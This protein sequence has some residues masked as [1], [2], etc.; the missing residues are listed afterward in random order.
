MFLSVFYVISRIVLPYTACGINRTADLYKVQRQ[1]LIAL[2]WT[3]QPM[4]IIKC[5]HKSFSF[6]FV[7]SF[8]LLGGILSR[9]NQTKK[10]IG[11]AFM[12]PIRFNL[13]LQEH[14]NNNNNNHKTF[15][16]C[17]IN[18]AP[19]NKMIVLF[20]LDFEQKLNEILLLPYHLHMYYIGKI[21]KE[22]HRHTK[23][24]LKAYVNDIQ[25]EFWVSWQLICIWFIK[26]GSYSYFIKAKYLFVIIVVDYVDEIFSFLQISF[27][28]DSKLL[29]FLYYTSNETILIELAN[30]I[31]HTHTRKILIINFCVLWSFF[32]ASSR[33]GSINTKPKFIDYIHLAHGLG[34]R[35][36]NHVA[37]NR[38]NNSFIIISLIDF[39]L[40]FNFRVSYSSWACV[41]ALLKPVPKF[42]QPKL[43]MSRVCIFVTANQ[44][45]RIICAELDAIRL[46]ISLIPHNRP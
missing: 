3:I 2:P 20:L 32:S 10:R 13:R 17:S 18:C 6:N 4:V 35:A 30:R 8:F 14:S 21:G 27:R 23:T 15:V 16:L 19:S 5:V 39:V 1:K 37:Q 29:S 26:N 33:C 38:N 9:S 25:Y 11:K 31:W 40:F 36:W 44:R 42:A 41:W 22:I 45:Q 12:E 24:Y 28:F 46:N 43:N 34:K 7:L